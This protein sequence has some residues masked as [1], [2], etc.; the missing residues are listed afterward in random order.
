MWEIPVISLDGD[1]PL[2]EEDLGLGYKDYDT[3]PITVIDYSSSFTVTPFSM[4]CKFFK[5]DRTIPKRAKVIC[6]NFSESI[7]SNQEIYFVFEVKLPS[8][9][10]T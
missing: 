4:N 3:F 2:F 6:A 7:T 5:G 8:V 9:S 10:V 1:F